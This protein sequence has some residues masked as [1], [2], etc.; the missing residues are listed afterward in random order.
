MKLIAILAALGFEQW[1]AFDWRTGAE[2]AFRGYAHAIELHLNG[3]TR[4]QGALALAVA[5]VPLAAAVALVAWLLV[6]LH[7]LLALVFDVA[8]LYLLMG[9]RHFS[10]ALSLII[11]ALRD[12]DLAAARR[13]LAGWRGASSTDL[14]GHDVAR[15]A[16]ERGLVD[17]YRQVFGVVFWF[18]VL[19]G[20]V[21]AVIYRLT[22][23]VAS[24]WQAAQPGEDPGP[25]GRSLDAFG[26]PVRRLL[27]LLD[28]LPS[29]LTALAF[30][31]VGDFEDAIYCWRAQA[32]HWPE[33]QGGSAAGIVLATGAGAL[34]VRLG[35]PLP[36]VSG[37]P[38]LRPD[39]GIGDAVEPEVLPSAVGLVW[40][41]LVLWLLL[42]LL[43]LL[44]NWAP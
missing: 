36:G 31:A 8:V 42:V 5:V 22:T 24:Q 30:A 25:L 39:L 28:W 27:W 15:L 14:S 17:A 38:E 9:F 40:R 23:L 29:R 19:P 32:R 16:V 4:G 20:P 11:A 13:A 10:H 33:A 6:S 3:G 12:G 34:G 7:P 2:R 37:E 26:Y 35:G 41:A 18:V 21:G 43:L 44:A 1:R